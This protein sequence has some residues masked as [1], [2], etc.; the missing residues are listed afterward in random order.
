MLGEDVKRVFF[1]EARR[2]RDFL[3]NLPNR[4]SAELFAAKT[5]GELAI[6][7]EREIHSCLVELS[8]GVEYKLSKLAEGTNA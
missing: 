6:R 5:S 7:L 4:I 3:L 2:S 1:E 8:N